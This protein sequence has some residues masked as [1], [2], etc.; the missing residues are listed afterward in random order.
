MTLE[1]RIK[2]LREETRW[3]ARYYCGHP[4]EVVPDIFDRA[5]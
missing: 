2:A 5:G 3:L 1:E 4:E